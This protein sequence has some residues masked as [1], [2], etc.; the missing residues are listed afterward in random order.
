MTS[1][2]PLA[3]HLARRRLDAALDN[4]AV[5]FRGMTAR[6]DENNCECHW[7]GAEELARL[8][9]PD[10]ELDH[11]L[12]Q[13]TW[14]ASDWIDHAAVLR[15]ILPQFARSLVAGRVEPFLGPEEIGRSFHRG[16]WQRWPDGQAAA[17]GEFLHAWWTRT[18]TDPA[19]AVPAH[20]LL[21]VVVEA[22]GTLTPWLTRWEAQ[23]GVPATQHLTEAAAHWEYHL[24]GD[25]LPWEAW[26][27]EDDG[28]EMRA[29]LTAWLLDHA[30]PRLIAHGAPDELLHR[31]R[32][33]G[34]TG[35]ARWEDPYWPD[36]R[37]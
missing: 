26:D 15:R 25:E 11:D 33:V 7:G 21:A 3:A 23:T 19:P 37:Y 32:L 20:E 29:E 34:L 6:P 31:I 5:T 28:G 14:R 22:S 17:V 35:P 36:H 13:R 27:S 10:I 16:R 18:L 1:S 30:R 12:L 9:V 2:R 24:L 4:L 8:K